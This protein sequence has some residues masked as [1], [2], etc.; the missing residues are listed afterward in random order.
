MLRTFS[1]DHEGDGVVA[2]CLVLSLASRSVANTTG[3]HVSVTGESGKGKSHAFATLLSQ[4][5]ERFRLNGAM[6]NKAL[7][8]I[9]EM[10][11]GTVIVLDDATLSDDMQE[12]LKGVTTSFR[13]PF[14]YRTVSRDRKGQVCTIPERCVWWVA[15]VEGSG[16]DQVFNRMLTCWIDDS[17]EQD[18][19]VLTRVLSRDTRPPA[20][21]GAARPEVVVC[22]AM[23]E[24]I[25]RQCIHVV[26]PYAAKIRFQESTNRRNPEMLL[27]LIKAN[28]VL[29]HRQREQLPAPPGAICIR[30]TR[31]DFDQ[32][33]R[34]YGLLNGTSGGQTTKLTKR[35][36]S[37]LEVIAERDWPEFTIP[38]LQRETGL[39]NGSLH[40]TIHGF[41]TKGLVYSGLLEKCPAI[42]FTDRTVVTE[43]ERGLYMRRRT[44]A[45][46]FDRNLY[47]SWSQGGS[48]WIDDDPDDPDP[49]NTSPSFHN[50]S[51]TSIDFHYPSNDLEGC[52][53]DAMSPDLQKTDSTTHMCVY[54]P[55]S[56]HNSEDSEQ[57]EPASTTASPSVCDP[58]KMEGQDP[59]STKQPGNNE[60]RPDKSGKSLPSE[61]KDEEGFAQE[62]EG[63]KIIHARDYKPLEFPEQTPCFVCGRSPSWFIEKLTAERKARPKDQWEGRRICRKCYQEIKARDQEAC[64]M[65]PGTVEVSR[66][67]PVTAY[68]GKCSLCDLD[69]A[70]YRDAGTGVLLCER[71][72]QG[73]V[74]REERSGAQAARNGRSDG[75]AAPEAQSRAE[76]GT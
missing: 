64:R 24:L 70:V 49:S 48:C 4:V 45:Y 33:A 46:T 54:D 51:N 11:P 1:L 38:M 60:S 37:L 59:K 17:P 19:R 25:G 47:T 67:Q 14:L 72:Y 34:L 28:A 2:E 13:D 44:N 26:I 56:F 5:P 8:Y 36:A 12:I 53:N 52:E 74:A 18:A 23:W 10:R 32:A 21:T 29:R 9:E 43:E 30:A 22:R 40:K 62:W 71:C 35:E 61:W 6:S 42:S 7:F 76:A 27:D 15:K 41:S 55:Q 63:Q 16:D 58:G 3:L 50:P 65:L 57:G 69:K 75:E 73:E 68:V 31:D 66:M 39:S 20:D